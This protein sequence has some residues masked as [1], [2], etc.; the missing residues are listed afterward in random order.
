MVQL[1]TKAV[2]VSEMYLFNYITDDGRNMPF[3][4]SEEDV[5]QILQDCLDTGNLKMEF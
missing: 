5:K 1:R 3:M 2:S 4:L